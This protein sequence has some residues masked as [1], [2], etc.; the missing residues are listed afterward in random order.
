MENHTPFFQVVATGNGPCENIAAVIPFR[1]RGKHLQKF[2]AHISQFLNSPIA[3]T[4]CWSFYF[5]EQYDVDLFNR[6]WLFNVGFA[7][8]QVENRN[9]KCITIQDLDTLP[10]VGAEVD[11]G[12]CVVPTQLSS[13]IECY[14]WLPP[15][16]DNAGGVVA[17]TPDH[18]FTV[19]GFSNSYSGWGGED[20]DLRLR[21]KA[22]NLLAAGKA[23][24]KPHTPLVSGC[25]NDQMFCV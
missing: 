25:A 7:M 22:T 11:F 1:G 12:D 2:F 6:G 15:Y 3:A 20:D 10:E 23:C 5:V 24:T 16:A 17:M 13:E 18:W 8:S 14:G 19:D 4:Y 9:F 21:L